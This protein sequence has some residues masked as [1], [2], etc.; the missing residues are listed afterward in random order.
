MTQLQDKVLPTAFARTANVDS[1]FSYMG[2][3]MIF[4]AKGSE[5][6]GRFALME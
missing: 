4:L 6:R 2:S 5:T 3:Q 1:T